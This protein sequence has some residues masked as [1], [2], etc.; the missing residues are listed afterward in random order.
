[1]KFGYSTD[2]G[3]Q[4]R[5]FASYS[6]RDSRSSQTGIKDSDLFIMENHGIDPTKFF[7]ISIF[8]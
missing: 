7:D 8:L 1:M 3:D 5:P 4:K 2:Q 6:S